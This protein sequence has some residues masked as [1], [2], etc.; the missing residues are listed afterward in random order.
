MREGG[1][2]GFP[3]SDRSLK[4]ASGKLSRKVR[5]AGYGKPEPFLMAMDASGWKARALA[6]IAIPMSL[7]MAPSLM[8]SGF[9]ILAIRR[10][11]SI[12]RI[13]SSEIISRMST[14]ELNET[15]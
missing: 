9:C 14:N 15:R 8:G 12:P 5:R 10:S 4:S 6:L 3:N 1:N 7:Q 11:A 2:A 13:F